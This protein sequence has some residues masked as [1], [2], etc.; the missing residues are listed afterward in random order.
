MAQQTI[1]ASNE[2]LGGPNTGLGTDAGDG[3][4]TVIAKLNAMFNDLYGGTV[5]ASVG[6]GSGNTLIESGTVT[7]LGTHQNSTPTAAQLLG[8][9]L[10]QTGATG[11]GTVTTPTGTVLSAA[12][13]G[14]ATGDSFQ[15][16]F[17]NLGGGFNLVI[18]AGASGMT[19]IGNATVPSGKNA[20]LDFIC[21]GANTWDCF[22]T[23][24]A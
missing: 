8:G 3:W 24:S 21:T 5:I 19:V 11:A 12:I 22:V 7:S 18:T 16:V 10:T 2:P 13:P 20:M 23:V 6:R 14:T 9:F 4:A 1:N 17:A 15:C